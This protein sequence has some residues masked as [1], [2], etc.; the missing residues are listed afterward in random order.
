MTRSVQVPLFVLSAALVTPMVAAELSSTVKAM[1]ADVTPRYAPPAKTSDAVA[2][3]ESHE[4]EKPRNGIIRLPRYL[5]QEA[6][7]PTFKESELYTARGQLGL[8]YQRHPGLRIG[9]IGPLNNDAWAKALLEEEWGI[10]RSKE[11]FELL[12]F[13]PGAN[14]GPVFVGR[15]PFSLPLAGSG[16]WAGLVVPWERR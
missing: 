5:V 7:P 15:P 9:S 2:T 16:P 14:P 11:M 6:K 10:E 3:E 12:R 13:V 4:T 1:L 8:G